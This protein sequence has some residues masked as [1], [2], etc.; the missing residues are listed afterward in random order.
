[1]NEEWL[2]NRVF[3]STIEKGDEKLYRMF[4][5]NIKKNIKE[6]KGIVDY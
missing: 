2:C 5:E 3:V 1:M 6:K 4:A